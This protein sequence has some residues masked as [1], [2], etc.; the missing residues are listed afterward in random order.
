MNLKRSNNQESLRFNVFGIFERYLFGVVQVEPSSSPLRTKI[1]NW[2]A[3]SVGAM[4]NLYWTANTLIYFSTQ[5]KQF[6]SLDISLWIFYIIYQLLAFTFLILI[7]R[8][9]KA[10]NEV[11]KQIII[12]SCDQIKLKSIRRLEI[13]FSLL[14]ALLLVSV[15]CL[16]YFNEITGFFLIVGILRSLSYSCYINGPINRFALTYIHLNYSINTSFADCLSQMIPKSPLSIQKIRYVKHLASKHRQLR[17]EINSTIGFVPFISFSLAFVYTILHFANYVVKKGNIPFAASFW[18]DYCFT[19]FINIFMAVCL[20]FISTDD[21][22]YIKIISWLTLDDAINHRDFSSSPNHFLELNQERIITLN[23]LQSLMANPIQ[24]NACQMFSVDTK[25]LL[26]FISSL[27]PFCV[28]FIQMY[29][30]N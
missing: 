16:N 24:H 7:W 9:F 17:E 14:F 19:L 20:G 3:R 11:M 5:I 18:I 12:N 21:Q 15:S 1:L 4:S 2:M 30:Q 26:L 29:Q 23:Y 6:D 10:V 25:F 8:R 13:C 22:M 28:M 27:I